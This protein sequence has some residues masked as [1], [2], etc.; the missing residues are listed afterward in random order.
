MSERVE[1]IAA[2]VH[3]AWIE[4]KRAQGV[5][6]R[7]SEWGEEQMVPYADLSERAKDLD[8]STVV[9]VLHPRP[10]DRWSGPVD[11]R[12]TNVSEAT[13][14]CS[15]CGELLS[16]MVKIGTSDGWCTSCLDEAADR[17]EAG[18]EARDRDQIAEDIWE[19][20]RRQARQRR[21]ARSRVR[22]LLAL[23]RL[24]DDD[25]CRPLW[26]SRRAPRRRN[27]RVTAIELQVRVFE[28]D[29]DTNGSDG[30][31][32]T[33]RVLASAEVEDGTVWVYLPPVDQDARLAAVVDLL[34]LWNSWDGTRPH[35]GESSPRQR[36]QLRAALQVGS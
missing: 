24:T 14:L 26:P 4:A 17:D 25:P 13:T 16:V 22:V 12:R 29:A 15:Q 20:A 33:E 7:P 23:P 5:T 1:Q 32:D 19:A 34:A 21:P 18:V 8:R 27:P 30:E 11:T 3:E 2:E 10:A 9:A 28:A 6:S 35:P 31:R 36:E